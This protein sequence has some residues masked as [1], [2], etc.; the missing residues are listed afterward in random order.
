MS[1]GTVVRAQELLGALAG[2][3]A[4]LRADQAEAIESVVDDRRRTL[5][6][7]R[8]GWGKSLTYFASAMILRERGGGPA[9]LIS[10]LLA[11]M[12]DQIAAA[13]RMGLRAVTINSSNKEDWEQAEEALRADE[14]DLLAISPER[15]N[16]PGFVAD[17]LPGL[18]DRVGLLIL[19]EAHCISAWGH[20]FRPDYLRI[21]TALTRLA[22]GTPV[23]A[24]TA[25]ATDQVVEDLAGQL[26]VEPVTLRGALERE[27][28]ALS[29]VACPEMADRLAWLAANVANLAGS[30]IVYTLTQAVAAQTATWLR[31]RGIDAEAYTG[32]TPA[33]ERLALEAAL[34]DNRIK[35]LVATSA[36][37]MGYDK[38]DLGFVINL[39]APS[40]IT[41]Y[42]QM[43]G[44]AGR[45]LAHAEAILLPGQEDARIWRYFD[46]VSFPPRHQAET[47]VRT[48]EAAS[49]PLSEATIESR[50]DIRRNRLTTMLKVLDVEGAARRVKG[51]WERSA[52][53]WVYDEDRY[54]RVR[55]ARAADQDLIVAYQQATSCRMAFLRQA[56]DDPELGPAWRC[57]RCD[58][59]RTRTWAEPAPGV[60]DR[61]RGT[62]RDQPVIL[63]ARKMW[64]AGLAE[65]KGRIPQSHQALDGR[66]LSEAGSAAWDRLVSATLDR[67]D[68]DLDDDLVG[69]IVEVLARWGWPDGRP[70]WVSWVPS[71]T[72]PRLIAA[73]AERIGRVGQLPVLPVITRVNDACPQRDQANSAHACGNVW[74]VFALDADPVPP[75]P[76]LVVDDIWASGWTMT[77]IAEMMASQGCGPVYPFVLQKGR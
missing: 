44:R 71:L 38:P 33:D 46:S 32:S 48:L 76:G 72:R 62:A 65:P 63:V 60:A 77:V 36:L 56:L 25:T 45:A 61:A 1:A 27:S 2:P 24:T 5:V 4:T 12:R 17:I 14:V 58:N 19:D 29:V 7:Q 26:G 57:G 55:A 6:V 74:G 59:C 31:S 42:Y 51:G 34:R 64:P 69:G 37:G 18:A 11:L 3:D 28:L 23:L 67:P 50:V 43:V 8:T 41:A 15:L 20:D 40:S 75:G 70:T 53:P 49:R 10:P 35:A 16:N 66:A 68:A 47:V 39:G 73:L 22:P 13:Q 9:L 21:R 54:A 30:G 52:R